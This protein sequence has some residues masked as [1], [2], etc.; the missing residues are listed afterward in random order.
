[1]ALWGG[2]FTQAADTRFKDFNDSLRFDYTGA[3]SAARPFSQRA[4]VKVANFY[5]TTTRADFNAQNIEPLDKYEEL[6]GSVVLPAG[7]DALPTACLTL[8]PGYKY[9][10]DWSAS[11]SGTDVYFL[12]LSNA[13]FH[14]MG[15]GA[16]E[17]IPDWSAGAF[18]AGD[19]VRVAGSYKY[20]ECVKSHDS[21]VAPDDNSVNW[22]PYGRI[23]FPLSIKLDGVKSG[24]NLITNPAALGGLQWWFGDN[25]SLGFKT[26]YVRMNSAPVDPGSSLGRVKAE[27]FDN[28]V[29]QFEQLM[30]NAEFDASPY[31]WR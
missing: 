4:L 23:T 21:L 25:D 28:Y 5:V 18:V 29:D 31:T 24:R 6:S 9:D 30:F 2:R 11:S 17:N 26:L 10:W 8:K 19:V 22:M 12:H 14:R 16:L 20:Y 27:F 15:V 13:Q 7:Q 3:G 1:M